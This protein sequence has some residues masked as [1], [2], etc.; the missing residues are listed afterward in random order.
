[1]T[2]GLNFLILL[3]K[4]FRWNILLC[5][6]FV[7]LWTLLEGILL[8]TI[9]VMVDHN[10]NNSIDNLHSISII[11]ISI[12]FIIELLIKASNLVVLKVVPLFLEELQKKL[13]NT[14]IYQDSYFYH[15]KITEGMAAKIVNISNIVENLFKTFLYGCI[16][17]ISGFIFTIILINL[18]SVWLTYCFLSWFI[19]MLLISLFLAKKTNN[20]S[21][22]FAKSNNT[23]IEELN[24]I[25]SN[26]TTVKAFNKENYEL[27]RY[28]KI[29]TKHRD[30]K[31]AFE[32]FLFNTDLLRSIVSVL[33]FILIIFISGREVTQNQATIG[34]LVF[35]ISAS[36][37]CKKDIWR[38]SL[39]IID[40]HKDWGFVQDIIDLLKLTKQNSNLC[41]ISN[42]EDSLQSI[43]LKNI[44]FHSKNSLL[45]KD[46]SLSIIK[47]EKIAIIG[48]SGSG[49]T[50]LAKLLACL[51]TPTSGELLLNQKKE[52]HEY[53]QLT[54][55]IVYI[56]QHIN[57]FDRS[58]GENIFYNHENIELISENQ[59]RNIT[60]LSLC[61]KFLNSLPDKLN[62]KVRNLSSGQ[63]HLVA[64]ARVMNESPEWIIL[65]E[66]CVF[67][68]PITEES[69]IKNILTFS[70]DKTL[71]VI[72]HSPKILKLMD[73]ILIIE[74]GKII[75]DSKFNDLQNNEFYRKFINHGQ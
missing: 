69:L 70:A 37:I 18:S 29:I 14:F 71:I 6:L 63:K 75:A 7:S 39:Q 59:V 34:D 52:S 41:G 4:K 73:R 74:S 16:A 8:Y 33:F 19:A 24:D 50:I 10:F 22:G 36:L 51:Y 56:D 17:G 40:I 53:T 27:N 11:F 32:V 28:G 2:E 49:K 62:T 44:Y 38:I 65:D 72:T 12:Y 54:K 47:G 25:L 45:I 13:A 61:D 57:L 48:S 43:E 64:I 46:I 3:F 5:C 15:D 1:M 68:D 66:P 20:Y 23:L 60:S 9:K 42:Q 55:K 58:I 21:V 30:I 67:L 35:I 26:F 31:Q